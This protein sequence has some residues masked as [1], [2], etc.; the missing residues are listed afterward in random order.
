MHQAEQWRDQLVAD[1]DALTALDGAGAR[2]PMCNTCAPSSARPAKTP[3]ASRSAPARR[4]ATARPTA[5]LFQLV[6]A[7]LNPD[8]TS[9]DDTDDSAPTSK[10]MSHDRSRHPDP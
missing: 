4:S 1:D 6:R 9:Q 3:K 7:T 5:K 2:R 10:P 8:D